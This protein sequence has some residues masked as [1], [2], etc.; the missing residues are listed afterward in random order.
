M[1]AARSAGAAPAAIAA[2]RAADNS[3]TSNRRSRRRTYGVSVADVRGVSR[4][5]SAL[6]KI[7]PPLAISSSLS[8]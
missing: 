1:L 4:E 8:V 3:A 5:R 7:L 2:S 6:A